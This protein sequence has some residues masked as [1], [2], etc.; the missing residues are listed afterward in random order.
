MNVSCP[1][2]SSQR[3]TGAH[4][5]HTA[6]CLQWQGSA[7]ESFPVGS[8]FCTSFL[9]SLNLVTFWSFHFSWAGRWVLRS[10]R[11]LWGLSQGSFIY[12]T[13][14]ISEVRP[15]QNLY[16]DI[17]KIHPYLCI[18]VTDK[19]LV[20]QKKETY[21]NILSIILH[22]IILYKGNAITHFVAFL[23]FYIPI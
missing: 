11:G 4:M 21:F 1:L 13:K 10:Q 7:C 20:F 5:S 6:L 19:N 23:G 14:F 15:S 16:P 17:L 9:W 18:M 12:S 8:R 2:P 22:Y 3:H